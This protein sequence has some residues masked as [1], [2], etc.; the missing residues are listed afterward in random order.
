[1][2]S[3]LQVLGYGRPDLKLAIVAIVAML[4]YSVF[5][6]A[7]L[8]S[9]IPFLEILFHTDMNL[10]A[11]EA[12]D[13]SLLTPSSLKEFAYYKLEMAIRALGPMNMLWYFCIA[14][15]G[16][17]LLKNAARFLSGWAMAPFEQRILMRMRNDLFTHLSKLSLRFYSTNKKGD[18]I[19]TLVSDVQL[20]QEAVISTIQIM[21]REPILILVILISL[22][23]LSWKL[24]LFVLIILP[25]T[26]F[27]INLISGTLKRKAR[28]GQRQLGDLISVLDEFISGMRIVKSFQRESFEQ[29]KYKARNDRYTD[30]QIGIRRRIELASPVTEWLSI[31][32]ICAIILF[33]GQ[34]ILAN[35]EGSPRKAEFIGFLVL[36]S[37]LLAPIKLISNGVAKIQKGMAAY[38]RVEELMNTP[39]EIQDAPDA[40]ALPAFQD[41]IRFE[42]VHFRYDREEVLK[43]ISFDLH[44]GKTVALVGPSGGG[45]STIADLIPRFYDPISGSISIDGVE[46]R[47]VKLTDLRSKLAI[48]SQEGIL[49]HDTVLANIA[50][51]EPSPDLESVKAAAM[52]AHA[53]EFITA[54]PQGYQTIIGERGTMLS[55]GQ[56]QRIAI[57]RAILRDPDFLILDEATSNLDTESE[58]FV[59]D[60]LEKLMKGRTSLVIAHRLSTIRQAD[61]I[62]VIEGGE[63]VERGT[64]E[65]LLQHSG[66]YLKLYAGA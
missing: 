3:Y 54:L 34:L 12:P 59:Q 44:K 15:L 27:F 56:R 14:L 57:A 47:Q 8:L 23:L 1:M 62:L 24:T 45:K 11:P 43:G 39:I 5:S 28:E 4:V 61:M 6:T 48:V 21:L 60:A 50:Y 33:A 19:G 29:N 32:V 55:G 63:I 20:I 65:E 17:N 53:H 36:F 25:I 46:L 35:T 58:T 22:L 64:H 9:A 7:T 38:Q 30:L 49:F 51:G 37:Q 52:M 66:L 18:L 13:M 16:L 10:A 31:L 2:R 26:G 42:D 40:V 41:R